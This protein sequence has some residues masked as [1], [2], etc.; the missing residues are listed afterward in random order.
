MPQ[1][2]PDLHAAFPPRA[3]Y[4]QHRGHVE[5]CGPPGLVAARGVGK[6]DYSLVGSHSLGLRAVAAR[7]GSSARLSS[8][9]VG[10][11]VP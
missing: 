8:R 3:D 9:A 6:L 7:T 1:R 4:I 10:D 5:P 2:Q 11:C